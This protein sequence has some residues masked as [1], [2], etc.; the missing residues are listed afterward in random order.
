MARLTDKALEDSLND[1]RSVRESLREEE[2]TSDINKVCAL[3][4][5]VF[6]EI[7]HAGLDRTEKQRVLQLI[8]VNDLCAFVHQETSNLNKAYMENIYYSIP[9]GDV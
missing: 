4:E 7:K 1:I 2:L 3:I 9:K 5:K 6:Y 8:A